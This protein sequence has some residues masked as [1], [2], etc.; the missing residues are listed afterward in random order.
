MNTT[1]SFFVIAGIAFALSQAPQVAIAQGKGGGKGHGGGQSQ[2]QGA[3]KGKGHDKEARPARQEKSVS[4]GRGRSEEVQPT[5]RSSNDQSQISRSRGTPGTKSNAKSFA[6]A[7]SVS[8]MPV[9]MRRYVSSGHRMHVVAAGALAH[10]FA[11][12]HE[13]DFRIDDAG[14][15]VRIL[16]RRGDA[17]LDLDDERA[18]NLGRWRVGLLDDQVRSGAPSFCRSGAGH[19]VWGREWCVDKGFG[20]GSYNNYRW[21]R[22]TDIGDIVF[23]RT[24]IASTLTT[25]A[26]ASLLGSNA[27]DRLALHAVTLGLVEPLTGRWVSQPEGPQVLYVDSGVYPVAEFV[28]TDRDFGLDDLLIALLPW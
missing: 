4:K 1:K 24:G 13:N 22:T 10:A 27:F 7:A 3:S 19:P 6:R 16:N 20:L 25:V 11:R 18:E 5:R 26:L 12:G 9:A 21:G 14:N 15:R 17:L 2:G 28:D 8:S 23:P